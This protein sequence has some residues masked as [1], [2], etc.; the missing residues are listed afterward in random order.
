M[1]LL[2]GIRL[3]KASRMIRLMAGKPSKKG[4]DYH[5]NVEIRDGVH[6]GKDV[7]H[8]RAR[9]LLTEQLPSAPTYPLKKR[10]EKGAPYHRSY[11]LTYTCTPQ[12]RARRN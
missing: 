7:I 6:E 3:D 2:K 4:A 11:C 9:A 1:R 8:T 5:V 12:F 10:L